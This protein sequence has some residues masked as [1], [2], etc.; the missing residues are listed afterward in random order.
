MIVTYRLKITLRADALIT[1]VYTVLLSCLN[2]GLIFTISQASHDIHCAVMNYSNI[3]GQNNTLEN[4]NLISCMNPSPD[5]G[6]TKA[7]KTIIYCVIIL[8]SLVGN[9][10]VILVVYKKR[11]MRTT[12]NFLIVNMACSDLLIAIFA[13]P[14][15]I[16]SIYAGQDLLVQGIL[17]QLVCKLVTF[18]QQVS[19]AV[20]I[21]SLAAIAFDRFFAILLPFRQIITAHTTKILISLTWIFGLVLAAPVLYTNRIITKEGSDGGIL[22]DEIW[23]PLL[24][25][26]KARKDYTFI[27][28]GFLYAGPLTIITILYTAIVIELWRGNAVEDRC[29]ANHQEIEKSN[30]KVLKMLVTVVVVFALF[31][32]PVYIFQFMYYV[33]GNA[34]LVSGLVQFI[35]YFLCQA[36]S[37]VNPLIFAIFSENYREGFM[38]CLLNI[39]HCQG[40][41]LLRRGSVSGRQNKSVEIYVL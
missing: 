15:T 11:R 38:E 3:T 28:F 41:N 24:D 33:R 23:E 26:N 32:L 29:C 12:T 16:R 9:T 8:V 34:C 5:T 18:F 39:R 2:C 40:R 7:W 25:S 17:A 4:D 14:P 6:L 22:C 19:I 36:T 31:W 10:L 20:S 27:S 37:A 13:M 30:R 1:E 35:G 21:F